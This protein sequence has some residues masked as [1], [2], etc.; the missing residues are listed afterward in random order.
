MKNRSLGALLIALVSAV[1]APAADQPN[2]LFLLSDDQRPDTVAALGNPDIR[3]PNLDRLAGRGAVFTR[4]LSNHPLCVPI[5]AEILT[6]CTGF[7]NGVMPG[8][9]NELNE[10]LTLWPQAMRDAGYRTAYVGKWHTAGRPSTRGYDQAIGLY[11][12]G[13]GSRAPDRVD[14]KNVPVTG[15]RG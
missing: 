4:A 3:T 9:T 15:Y 12:S 8:F 2:V 1:T 14:F 5:R 11:G 6:G 7:T 13:M 10:G